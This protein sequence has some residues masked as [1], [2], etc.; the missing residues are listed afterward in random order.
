MEVV[1]VHSLVSSFRSSSDPDS[2]APARWGDHDTQSRY[3]IVYMYK[4]GVDL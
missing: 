1:C 2:P 4:N 3:S